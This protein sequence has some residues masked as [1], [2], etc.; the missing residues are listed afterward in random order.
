MAKK[1]YSVTTYWLMPV[2]IE[3]E[4]IYLFSFVNR[5]KRVSKD[6]FR[7]KKEAVAYASRNAMHYVKTTIRREVS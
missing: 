3:T 2:R 7:T 5:W 4:N 6:Y 1:K